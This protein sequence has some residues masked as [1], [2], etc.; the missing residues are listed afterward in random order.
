MNKNLSLDGDQ[1][2]VDADGSMHLPD[3]AG[4]Y[5]ITPVTIQGFV[6]VESILV[7]PDATIFTCHEAMNARARNSYANNF[8][9]IDPVGGG[10]SNGKPILQDEGYLTEL[11]G[12]TAYHHGT[13]TPVTTNNFVWVD[14]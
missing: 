11:D 14:V 8:I 4:W 5:S 2:E 3:G 7:I 1:I 13:V 6:Y 10:M 12:V 9:T